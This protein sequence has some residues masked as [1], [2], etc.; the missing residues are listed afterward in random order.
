MIRRALWS[1]SGRGSGS[2]AGRAWGCLGTGNP[3][4]TPRERGGSPCGSDRQARINRDGL[5]RACRFVGEKYTQRQVR[6]DNRILRA[7]KLPI[8][9]YSYRQT[10]T[11]QIVGFS[12]GL[13]TK[14][15]S[16]SL[17]DKP[18]LF[19]DTSAKCRWNWQCRLTGYR[20]SLSRQFP[21]LV[22]R[23]TIGGLDQTDRH[24]P[25]SSRVRAH[26]HCSRQLGFRWSNHS[27]EFD[28]APLV[29][30][31]ME[32]VFRAS[33][34]HRRQT[35]RVGAPDLGRMARTARERGAENEL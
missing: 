7:Y 30:T 29:R 11:Y 31:T 5:I 4:R 17:T 25:S 27:M 24:F 1:L 21:S 9:I 22:G 32:G 19:A 12:K 34:G 18:T 26:A 33:W 6:P 2:G 14:K 15:V 35:V 28:R 13:S 10:D 23:S 8:L 3:S 16:V 20:Q